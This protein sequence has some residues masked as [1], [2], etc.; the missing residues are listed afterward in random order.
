[1]SQLYN[2]LDRENLAESVVRALLAKSPSPLGSVERFIGPGLYA[3]YYTGDL[4]LYASIADKNADGKF[5]QPIYCGKAI[6]KGGRKG[7]LITGRALDAGPVL[8]E[9]LKEHADSIRTVE[10]FKTEPLS[11]YPLRISDFYC[12]YL[13]V[14]DVWIPLAESLLI[15]T[16]T[17]IWNRYLDGFGNHDPGIGRYNGKRPPWDVVHPGRAWAFKCKQNLDQPFFVERLNSALQ[18]LPALD[19]EPDE[20]EDE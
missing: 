17:P 10:A 14:D 8:W 3:I 11:A 2:P 7:R 16:Y 13:T 19:T 20:D 5:D 12:R 4:P 1:V 18:G 9:R 6:P 15:S